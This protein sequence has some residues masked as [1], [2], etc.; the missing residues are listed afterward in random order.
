MKRQSGFSLVELMVAITLALLLTGALLS[1]F[2][3]SRAAF[4][5]TVG[6]AALTDGG[7]FALSF[8]QQSLRSAGYMACSAAALQGTAPAGSLINPGPSPLAFN[9][10]QGV[11]GFEAAATGPAGALVLPPTNVPWVADGAGGDWAAGNDPANYG[12]GLD[13]ALAGLVIKGSDV[14]V[15][16]GALPGATAYVT[17]IVDG[18]TNFTTN[19]AASLAVGQLAVISDCSKSVAFVV[20]G[21]GGG[22]PATISHG[23]GGPVPGNRA[24][25]FDPGMSFSSGALVNAVNTRVYYIGVG[26]DGDGAL[27]VL[28]LNGTG[29]FTAAELVPDIENMQVLYGIDTTGTQAAS[30]YVTADQVTDF[31]LVVSVKIAVLAASAATAR[32]PPAAAQVFT[33]LGTT[34]TAPLDSRV[35]KVFDVSVTVRNVV[36]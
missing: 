31:N 19:T 29:T 36:N 6:T 30:Q 32:Q 15:T 21:V 16:R 20:T 27:W 18:A 10:G 5:S 2:A 3:G 17:T 25:T 1:V 11:G 13:P 14:L 33:L 23:A 7:R 35:R 28:D 12:A 8:M 34:V 24:G 9:F 22:A 4:R 26:A